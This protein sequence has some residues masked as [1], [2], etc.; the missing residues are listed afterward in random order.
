MRAGLFNSTDLTSWTRRQSDVK[1]NGPNTAIGRVYPSPQH[2]T[3]SN[4]PAH[5][6]V[7]ATESGS[8]WAVN[9]NACASTSFCCSPPPLLLLLRVQAALPGSGA[10]A[11]AAAGMANRWSNLRCSDGD[12]SHGWVTL[13]S[14]AAHG[15]SLACPAV[16]FL[17]SDGYY[18]TVSGG[19]IIPLQ[20]SRDLLNCESISS[21]LTASLTS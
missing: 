7:M 15:G 14:S 5:G 13:P 16:R 21:A 11:A 3:P 2:P 17:P 12:L 6:Y 9:N 4:L 20:R 8:T 19:S 18:Y 1:W 10:A